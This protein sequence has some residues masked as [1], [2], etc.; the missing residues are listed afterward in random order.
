MKWETLWN[1]RV[2]TAIT[3]ALA[4]A[5]AAYVWVPRYSISP[6][7]EPLVVARGKTGGVLRF[8]LSGVLGTDRGFALSAGTVSWNGNSEAETGV[9]VTF[10]PAVG[11]T[12]ARGATI[13]V[14]VEGIEKPG[15]YEIPVMNEGE[16][17]TRLT[18]L[19]SEQIARGAFGP[20]VTVRPGERSLLILEN[21]SDKAVP[22]L[23]AK[24]RYRLRFGSS[25]FCGWSADGV[26]AVECADRNNWASIEMNPFGEAHIRIQP[27]ERWFWDSP[28]LF[29]S[30]RQSGQL[31]LIEDKL[32]EKGELTGEMREWSIP[33]AANFDMFRTWRRLAGWIA[34]GA[35]ASF[36]LSQSLPNLRRKERLRARLE[37]VRQKMREVSHL[38][39]P[40]LDVNLR[41]E[42]QRLDD[43]RRSVGPIWP[44]YQPLAEQVEE[45]VS[46]L[47]KRVDLAQR[48]DRLLNRMHFWLTTNPPPTV[49]SRVDTKQRRVSEALVKQEPSAADFSFADQTL[50]ELESVSIGGNPGAEETFRKELAERFASLALTLLRQPEPVWAEDLPKALAACEPELFAALR[51]GAD[52]FEDWSRPLRLADADVELTYAES[53]FE[54]VR[55]TRGGPAF[56]PERAAAFEARLLE[57]CHTRNTRNAIEFRSM[58]AEWA[59][60]IFEEDIVEELRRGRVSILR[61]PPVVRRNQTV[62]FR[63]A[64]HRADLNPSLAKS[65]LQCG[66]DLIGDGR[67]LAHVRGWEI[68]RYFPLE[69]QYTVRVNFMSSK[70]EKIEIPCTEQHCPNEDTFRPQ[71]GEAMRDWSKDWREAIYLMATLVIPVISVAA[72][73]DPETAPWSLFTLGFTADKIKEVL[74]N[75]S[76]QN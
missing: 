49:Y 64:F 13:E 6:A 69:W 70:G 22:P 71:K 17:L 39:D 21:R 55:L 9:K 46:Q 73:A 1:A 8:R 48:L 54:Y 62:R 38:I 14:R 24:L 28:R 58:L 23:G 65:N 12:G 10:Q 52:S 41:T 75:R 56:P 59:D 72:T 33:V 50:A 30:G 20:E 47:E 34:L 40:L 51:K 16:E 5:I 26:T 32:N 42:R 76:V 67:T 74:T 60:G 57:L 44:G 15:G 31:T 7:Y 27:R 35:L 4:A 37:N 63:V 45:R 43:L 19:N 66:W 61:D 2:W 53:I 68:A 36:F 11:R 3:A 18:V 29:A 25:D